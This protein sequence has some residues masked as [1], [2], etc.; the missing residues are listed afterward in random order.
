VLLPQ[1]LRHWQNSLTPCGRDLGVRNAAG[2][3]RASRPWTLHAPSSA[4]DPDPCTGTCRQPGDAN[5][6]LR[7][8]QAEQG[9]LSA[10]PLKPAASSELGQR[11]ARRPAGSALDQLDAER[12][13]ADR[14]PNPDDCAAACRS[15]RIGSGEGAINWPNPFWPS[16]TG[17]A[18]EGGESP[19]ALPGPGARKRAC[20][21]I[22]T[23]F[24]AHAA[25]ATA[26]WSAS[27]RPLPHHSLSDAQ[28]PPRSHELNERWE[29]RGP[30]SLF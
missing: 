1:W 17:E 16:I 25:H 9:R 4:H 6:R 22:R 7:N 19:C 29:T 24:S 30:Y 8:T 2:P 21:G 18:D 3:N 15:W 27:G 12:H 28:P 14:Y 13:S 20:S 5:W 26:A 10:P 11:E 23:T